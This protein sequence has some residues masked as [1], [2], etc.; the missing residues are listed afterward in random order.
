MT[1]IFKYTITEREAGYSISD[2]LREKGYSR[3]LII[4]LKKTNH[5]IVLNDKWDY[6]YSK[7]KA[8]DILKIHLIESKS[9]AH[10]LPVKMDLDIVY[11]D[12]DLMVINKP[13]NMPIHPS[14][15]NYDNTLANG[16]LEYFN[17][18]GETFVYRC[19][20]RLDRDTTG[21]LIIAKNG[22]SAGILSEMGK[23]R[24]IDRTYLA[25]V[26]GTPPSYGRID[27]PIGRVPDSVIEREVRFLDG[28]DA[29][30]NYE[31]IKSKDGYSLVK[32]KLETGRTHQI[33]VH[34]KH[35]GYPLIGDYL[36]YPDYDKIKRQA[37]HSYRIKFLHP[38][39]GKEMDFCAE[40]PEDMRELV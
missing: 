29:V 13:C 2:F 8:G 9:P 38:I 33:R 27:A 11:E 5:G 4:H 10:I 32:L 6:V 15:G 31:V 40:L 22:L 3:K 28:E 34:M 35:I 12:V 39:T 1:R 25:V 26:K 37:L 21:L 20:N 7:L 18:K 24:K 36:Y 17:Q 23:R 14:M 30:T 16:I 19:I